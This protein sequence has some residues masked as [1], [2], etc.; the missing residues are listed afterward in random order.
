MKGV[1]VRVAICKSISSLLFAL[2]CLYCTAQQAASPVKSPKD[3]VAEAREKLH[4]AELA[5]P[6]NT[7]EVAQAFNDLVATKL[8]VEGPTPELLEQAKRGL[9][10]AE[11]AAGERGKIFVNAL[12]NAAYVYVTLG[13]PAEGRPFADRAFA[14]SIQ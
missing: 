11:A 5:H 14:R 10:I 4:A 2:L 3:E 12:A 1:T 8:G 9:T 6:G 7:V 13:R